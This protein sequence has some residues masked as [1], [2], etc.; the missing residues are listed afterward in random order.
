MLSCTLSPAFTTLKVFL[1][2]SVGNFIGAGSAD[3]ESARRGK[4]EAG[5]RS[6]HRRPLL[7]PISIFTNVF[8]GENEGKK[9]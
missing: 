6:A 5:D 4:R 7:P 2:P 8:M 1:Q 3:G 9:V